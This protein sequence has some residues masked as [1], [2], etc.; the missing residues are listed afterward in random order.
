MS[1]SW[2]CFHNYLSKTFNYWQRKK[3]A[4]FYGLQCRPSTVGSCQTWFRCRQLTPVLG[5]YRTAPYFPVSFRVRTELP[6]LFSICVIEMPQYFSSEFTVF[7]PASWVWYRWYPLFQLIFNF[8]QHTP[9]VHLGLPIKLEWNIDL[10]PERL[11]FLD[12]CLALSFT[13]KNHFSN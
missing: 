11:L 9:E 4:K 7:V 8:P 3:S 12:T 5:T 13:Q 6:Q 1:S 2:C 10:L